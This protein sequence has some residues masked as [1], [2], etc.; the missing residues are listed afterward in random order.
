MN[1]RLIKVCRFFLRLQ[2]LQQHLS[3]VHEI[4]RKTAGQS[5][6]CLSFQ[7]VLKRLFVGNSQ[8]TILLMIDRWKK[9]FDN[10]KVFE[11]VLTDLSK[12]FHYISHD[13][14]IAKLNAYGL[15][16]PALKLI[17]DYLQNRKQT[18]KIGSTYSD[19]EDII[20][21]VPQGSILVPL[22]FNIFLCDLF[23]EDENNYFANYA[24]NTTPY[25]VGSATT[26]VLENLSGTTKKL[27][28]WFANN[29]MKANDDKCHLLLSSPDDSPVIQ[30][31]NSTI[32]C[33]KVKK[34]LGVHIDY[35]LKL[36]IHVETICKKAHRKLSALSRITNYMELPKRRIL[37]NAFFKA[38]FNYC[39]IIW[40]FHSHCLNNKINRLMK[41]SQNDL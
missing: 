32:K 38:Q 5:V 9:A 10:H 24:D 28:T 4:K 37:M 25:S 27:F 3:K 11:V 20:S 15:S 26:E 18:T 22:L 30:I 2:T 36:D 19:W 8:I 17:T 14:L 41:V 6:F 29:Q 21:G 35:K 13:L 12:V 23:L 40:M 16:L 34:L 7:K 39:P 33:S 31:E 1:C